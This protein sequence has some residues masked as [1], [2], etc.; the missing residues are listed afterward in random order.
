MF[1]FTVTV[2]LDDRS[3]GRVGA[4]A[5]AAK[6][7]APW[8]EGGGQRLLRKP[9]CWC[10]SYV[11]LSRTSIQGI[12]LFSCNQVRSARK[13]MAAIEKKGVRRGT[14]GQVLVLHLHAG[15]VRV[16][17]GGLVWSC[18]GANTALS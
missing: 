11:D 8:G 7:G 14:R 17:K 2:F 12:A 15:R 1:F 4:S 9:G 13:G 5:T 3:L 18:R 10:K 6:Q 16:K